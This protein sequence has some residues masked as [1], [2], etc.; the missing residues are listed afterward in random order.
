MIY[1]Y[2]RGEK[3]VDKVASLSSIRNQLSSGAT[4]GV[5]ISHENS[6]NECTQISFLKSSFYL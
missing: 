3:I 4:G 1:I 6:E 2:T 5:L